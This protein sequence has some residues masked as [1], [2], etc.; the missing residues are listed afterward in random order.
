MIKKCFT[1]LLCASVM[2]SSMLFAGGKT[3]TAPA[4]PRDLSAM[5]EVDRNVSMELT[6]LTHKQGMEEEFA[7]YQQEF[8]KK[9]PNV[10]IVYEPIGD[11]KGNIEIRW[12]SNNWGDMCMIPHNFISETQ[13][14]QLFA[15]LGKV[16]DFEKKYEFASAFSIDGEVYG[17]S[18][19]GTAYGVL[20]N[21]AV[22]REAGVTEIPKTPQA[23]FDALRKV[24]AN[25]DAIPLYCNYGAGSRLADWEWNAR[26]SL[27]GDANYK[28]KMI[29][30][31]NPFSSGKPYN[32]VMG[33]LYDVVAEDLVEE[34]PATSTWDTCKNLLAQGKVAAT[35]IGS[36]ATADTQKTAENPSDIVFAAFPWNN[37]GKQYATIAADYAYA[38]NKNISD[39]RYQ[40]ARDYIIYLTEESGFSFDSGGIPIMKGEAYPKT[41]SALQEANV[42]LVLDTPPHPDDIGLFDELNSESELY[43]GKYPE[44]ARVV[45]AAMGQSNESF[46]EIMEDWNARWTA[47]QISIIGEDYA[48]KSRYN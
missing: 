19:T 7:V 11:Y 39:E 2:L 16:S 29:Y 36:W 22:L 47:A 34:D 31:E 12:T 13:L 30:M 43:L 3:E 46:D 28:N 17:I 23:F 21:T 15:P 38:I 18:S 5:E 45:E 8:N 14:P 4:E 35:V 26:G 20:Y 24:R 25:T 33:M 37:D 6:F 44:K 1:L 40:V 42:T 32:T 9:Y 27:T 41:L 10:K 48:S